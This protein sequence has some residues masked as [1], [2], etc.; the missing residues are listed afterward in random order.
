[1]AVKTY[2][3]RQVLI[4]FRDQRLTGFADGDMITFTIPEAFTG[5]VGTDGLV[6]RIATNNNLVPFVVR[7]SQTADANDVLSG[8]F[9]SDRAAPNGAGVGP[10]L[11][12]DLLGRTKIRLNA[13]ISK[14]PDPNFGAGNT[15]REWQFQGELVQLDVGGNG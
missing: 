13:W 12:Q 15:A 1:M 8:F 10:F 7:A 14:P 6:T 11:V 5:H 9:A 3:P 2:D 4:S